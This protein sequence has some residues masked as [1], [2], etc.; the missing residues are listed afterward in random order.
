MLVTTL[1]SS[2]THATSSGSS[3]VIGICGMP[4]VM[5]KSHF[6]APAHMHIK[7]VNVN[8]INVRVVCNKLP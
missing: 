1:A 5:G 2:L 4:H 8:K 3:G 7:S 6:G